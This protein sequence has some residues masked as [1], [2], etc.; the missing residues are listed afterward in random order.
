LARHGNI[1][2]R[3]G[4]PVCLVVL[5]GLLVAGRLPAQLVTN[6][7]DRFDT[8]SYPGG[9]ITNKWSNWFGNAFQSLSFDPASDANT[10]ASS[11][12]LKIVANF[13]VT[14]D[15]FEVW[16]GI[17]G[18]SPAINGFQFTNFQCDVRFAAGSATNSSGN[19]GS[20]QFGVP[21][22]SYG[23]DY[24]TG[25][26]S[27]PA[28]NTNWV[29]IS[30][31]LNPNTDT[32]LQSMIGL[33]IHIWGAGLVGPST[34]W[35]DNLQFVG[36]ASTGTATINYTNTQQRIDGFGASSAWYFSSLSTSDADLLFSTNTGMGLSFLR[37][38]IAPGGIIDDS[39]GTIAQQATAR[40]AR[41]WSTPWTPAAGF[42]ITNSWNR[43][44]NSNANNG[45][46]FSNNVANCQGY[47]SQLA[48]YVSTMKNTYGVSLYGVSVQNEPD[49]NVNYESC[50]WTSQSIHDFVPYLSAALTASNVAS[51]Q[52]ILPEDANWKWNLAT[53][54]MADNT[55]SNL[56]GVLAAHNYGSSASP[57]TQFGTPCPKT[58]WETEHYIDTDDSITNALVV[59]QEI[60]SFLTV[61]QANAYHYWWLTGSG[62]G[63]IADNTANPAKR[64]FAMGNYSKFIRPNFYRVAVTNTATALVSAYKDPAS[65]NFVIVAANNSAF[66]VN[67]IFTLTNFPVIGPLRQWVTSATEPLSNHGGAITLTNGIFATVLPAW[68]VSTF[69][70]QQPV[71]NPP[72]IVQQPSNQIA[73]PGDTIS[74]S[75]QAIGGTAPLYYQWLFNGTNLVG[76]TN[77]S[78]AVVGASLTNAGFYSVI[79]TNYA[80]SVTSSVASLNLIT[81]TWNTAVTISTNAADVATNGTFLYAYN[82]SGSS[83]TVNNVTFTGVNSATVWGTNVT[84]GGWDATSTSSYNGGTSTPWNS[85]P[86]GYKT[87]L[88]GGVYNN[89]GNTASVTLNNLTIGHQYQVQVWVNDSRSGSTT[90]RTETLPGVSGSTVT[91][92]YNSTYAGGGV[93]QYTLGTFTATATNQ[94][95]TMDGNSSTQLNALQVRDVTPAAVIVA[96]AV[97]NII[98]GNSVLLTANANGAAPFA[99]KWYDNHT[100]AIAWGTNTSLT[101]TNPSVAASGNYFVV[102]Q[103]AVNLATN[104]AALTVTKAALTVTA[105][106]TNRAYGAAN[107]AFTA[108]YAGFVNGDTL[109]MLS[110]APSLTTPATSGSLPGSYVIIA[111]NG[112]LAATNYNFTFVNGTLVVA[113]ASYPT[114]FSLTVNGASFILS[115]PATHLGWTLQAQTNSLAAGLGTNWVDLPATVATNN[116]SAP[117]NPA[118][119]SV[120]YRLRR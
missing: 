119:N 44:G 70:Y 94:I 66:P 101:L 82:N 62:T 30:I 38:R 41:V 98:Y 88:Q 6:V 7:I 75:V 81:I 113:S 106:N 111:T 24:F 79:V 56:V 47:A 9:T 86:S 60:H 68:T 65:S 3:R 51:T 74:F 10:N 21:T 108:S 73:L 54:T 39:E 115:W 57:V 18:F 97:T 116:F 29:H 23:Q 11:G 92:A 35:V 76:A 90:N 33:L 20:V 52:I 46:W 28:S 63:S 84:L 93:G 25:G 14:T 45:G 27:I 32:N 2:S 17:S 103:N 40:G 100:N 8:N 19:F 95:F 89:S 110:G 83:A 107:P 31:A 5:I 13:P 78:M 64:L 43:T 114:N 72:S 37:T 120:F 109:A 26:N 71:T 1:K 49:E 34:L 36:S 50:Q 87:A 59:A 61:A 91:L 104:F 96:P 58:L 67:Q 12:S 102:V 77:A 22:P 99:Y 55:T 16:N 53:N 105:N 69:V 118:N 85:L 42:K 48:N 117:L 4:G 112:T 80:G 15:Q